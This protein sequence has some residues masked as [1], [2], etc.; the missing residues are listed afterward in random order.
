MSAVEVYWGMPGQPS[1][2]DSLT[3]KQRVESMQ[4]S[5]PGHDIEWYRCIPYEKSTKELLQ[6]DFDED[7][8]NVRIMGVT[9]TLDYFSYEHLAALHEQSEDNRINADK[10]REM[11]QL[12]YDECQQ[13]KEQNTKTEAEN[14]CLRRQIDE[15]EKQV[16]RLKA[17]NVVPAHVASASVE[18]ISLEER[19]VSEED[20]SAVGAKNERNVSKNPTRDASKEER[21]GKNKRGELIIGKMMETNKSL[22]SEV[23]AMRRQLQGVKERVS[24]KREKKCSES[25]SKQLE[26]DITAVSAWNE[27][28]RMKNCHPLLTSCAPSH[29]RPSLPLTAI[30][31]TGFNN[32][33]NR[34]HSM[35]ALPIPMHLKST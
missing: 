21:D 24:E 23:D 12:G 7:V 26:V 14:E 33:D 31:T 3:I 28:D 20:N 4:T 19:N 32:S 35:P 15:L 5:F 27:C 18:E 6:E 29:R 17:F 30:S 34:L 13:L 8:L 10:F 11:F 2:D 1:G 25:H 22:K 9:T 16:G